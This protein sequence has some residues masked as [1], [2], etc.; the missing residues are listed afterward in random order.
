MRLPIIPILI[1]ALLLGGILYLFNAGGGGDRKV[2][3]APRLSRLTDVD[4]VETEVAIS[5]DGSH[6]AIISDGDLWMVS[7]SDGKKVRLTQT[8]EPESFPAWSPDGRRVTF[9]RGPDTFVVP[10]EA[11]P[12]TTPEIF[13]SDAT[14]LSWAT[15]G[16]TTYV[17]NRGLW[18]TDGG[19][20]NDKQI[21]APDSNPNITLRNPRFSPDTLQ[22]AFIKRFL[23]IDGQVWLVDAT[24]TAP[25]ALVG[26]R[27]AENPLDVGWILNGR[28][29]VYLTD[30]SGSYSIWYVNFADN[31]LLPLT[32]PLF[33][34][35]LA[36]VGISVWKDRIVVPRH[37][38]ESKI[39][40]SDGQTIAQSQTFQFQP[41]ASPDGKLVTY[42]VV[43]PNKMEVWTAGIDGSNPAFRTDGFE[44]RFAADGFHVIYT[45]VDLTGNA[46]IW[47]IDIRNGDTDRITDAEELDITPDASFDGR[48]ITFTST[49]GVAPSIWVV[50]SSGGKRLRIND[51]GYGPRFSRDGKS[52]IFWSNGKFSIMNPEG[53]N[54]RPAPLDP[55]AAPAIAGWTNSTPVQLA[56]NEIRGTNG[57]TLFKSER[58]LWPRFDILPDGRFL[59]API[60]VR[61]TGIWAIDL[62]FKQ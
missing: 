59:I 48:W 5:P 41:A 61:E 2:M 40:L 36:P 16:R 23:D 34:R 7:L 37:F 18:I 24:G 45:H 28:D 30:R 13:K 29:L 15:S 55:A 35:P 11:G 38:V 49:R 57:T 46:D 10:A 39:E 60:D 51:G 20:Q 21:V 6:C 19:A 42:T 4:G 50:P 53:G 3:D 58:P 62:Q 12:D 22:I 32:Q 44:P 8:P 1:T 56:G 54:I 33:D 31:T 9:S 43:K 27:A 26:D 47:R 25:H 14:N 52:I 17:R